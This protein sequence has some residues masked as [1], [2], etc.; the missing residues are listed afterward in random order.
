MSTARELMATVHRL[1]LDRDVDGIAGLLA[2]DV[3]IENPF[4]P[5]DLPGRIEGRETFRAHLA[6]R[7]RTTAVVFDRFDQVVVHQTVDPEVI[8]IEFELHGRVPAGD[9]AFSRQYI[10]VVRVAGGKVV[11]WRDYFNPLGL[12]QLAAPGGTVGT[13]S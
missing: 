11:H 3:V 2:E 6:Q 8:V 9:H 5:A 12:A 10:Q 1:F 4:A 7:L 13:A